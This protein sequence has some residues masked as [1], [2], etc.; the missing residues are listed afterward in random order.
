MSNRQYLPGNGWQVAGLNDDGTVWAEPVI[1]WEFSGGVGI[2]VLADPGTPL[3]GTDWVG[4]NSGTWLVQ[5]GADPA[6][7]QYR[8]NAQVAQ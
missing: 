8:P 6:T 2:P 7:S 5:P 1:A 3:L 4:H